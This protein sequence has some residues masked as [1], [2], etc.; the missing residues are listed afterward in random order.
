MP[1]RA[2]G[3]W[4]YDPAETP[5]Q[6][7]LRRYRLGADRPAEWGGGGPAGT[8]ED[9]LAVLNAYER[10]RKK[11]WTE[12]ER[13][14]Q[15]LWAEINVH[16][17]AAI[18]AHFARHGTLPPSIPLAKFTGRPV[19]AARF[20]AYSPVLSIVEQLPFDCI[21]NG[22]AERPLGTVPDGCITYGEAV[23]RLRLL[24]ERARSLARDL[25][26]QEAHHARRRADRDAKEAARKAGVEET[27]HWKGAAKGKDK[28]Q[29]KKRGRLTCKDPNATSDEESD[30]EEERRERKAARLKFGDDR[31]AAAAALRL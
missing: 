23:T 11:D 18:N 29:P 16:R 22:A 30:S 19:S 2:A 13:A 24:D 31:P 26:L 1:P 6:R 27:G 4:R 28:P 7:E 12:A 8:D 25:E 14:V 5:K 9:A 21:G 17:T 20:F 3:N 10:E 15:A